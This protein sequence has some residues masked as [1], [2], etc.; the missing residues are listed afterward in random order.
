MSLRKIYPYYRHGRFA[1]SPVKES[2]VSTLWHASKAFF[3]SFFTWSQPRITMD[4]VQGALDSQMRRPYTS[5][6]PRVTVIGHACFLIQCE[7][8]TIITDPVFSTPSFLMKRY[9]TLLPDLA[10]LPLVDVVLISHNHRDHLDRR[11]L[12]Y[13]HQRNP[14][15]KICVPLGDK[16]WCL[17]NGFTNVKEYSWWEDETLYAASGG[18]C[19]GDAVCTFL[20]AFHWS[21]RGL[22]DRNTSLWGSWMIEMGGKKIYFAGDTAQGP[23]FKIIA[24]HF[25]QIDVACIPIGPC[26]PADWLGHTHLTTEQ[27]GHAFCE[28]GARICLPMHWGVFR[29]GIEHPFIALERFQAWWQNNHAALEASGKKL[30]VPRFSESFVLD[31]DVQ[32]THLPLQLPFTE[33]PQQQEGR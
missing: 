8:L 28:L 20:P 30:I 11:S 5:A 17:R 26:D 2:S 33:P 4:E 16:A 14:D 24:S 15:L 3:A 21:Q 12:A 9:T 23:H 27:A 13:L 31:E 1:N 10:A 22:F 6:L 29:M 18:G 25:P 19:K 7:G 32:P